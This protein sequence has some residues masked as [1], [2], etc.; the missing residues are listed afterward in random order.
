M[1]DHDIPDDDDETELTTRRNT[2]KAMGGA[3]LV[4]GVAPSN[5]VVPTRE[6]R[7][8]EWDG[9]RGSEFAEVDCDD[10]A[11]VWQWILTKGG[12]T[13]PDAD[14]AELTV[15]FADGTT[16]TAEGYRPGQGRG[17]V[18]FDVTKA[19][20]GTV[21]GATAAFVGGNENTHLTISEVQC[22]EV[23]P[24]ETPTETEMPEEP[25]ETPE[26]P[27]ETPEAPGEFDGLGVTT[28]CRNGDGVIAVSNSNDVAVG[29]T[30]TG[31]D[32]YEATGEA[33]A[34]DDV[35][36]PGLANGTYELET[37]HEDIGLE[38]TSVVI[39]Y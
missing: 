16:E 26:E 24:T 2:L 9:Q 5:L 34:G 23:N 29:V 33:P 31:P 36:F 17:A 21:D 8:L 10:V 28:V 4:L 39:D 15:E 12:P 32:G 13:P 19:G 25:T 38:Q 6:T 1:T 14:G 37:D 7:T 22:S 27:T 35:E 3:G 18:H 30:V 20:G 11:A